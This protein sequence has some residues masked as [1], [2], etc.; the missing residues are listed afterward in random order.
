MFIKLLFIKKE[1]KIKVDNDSNLE[2][3]FFKNVLNLYSVFI[4]I[5]HMVELVA[6][7]VAVGFYTIRKKN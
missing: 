7:S 4:D 2:W 1:F 6:V 5:F 3:I